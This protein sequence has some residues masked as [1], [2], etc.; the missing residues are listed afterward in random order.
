MRRDVNPE[1]DAVSRA[2]P[3][4]KAWL[5][6]RIGQVIQGRFAL[7]AETDLDDGD[8]LIRVEYAAVSRH[9]ALA[10]CGAAF[11]PSRLPCI[12][13]RDLVGE[14]IASSAPRFRCGDKVIATGY[15]LGLKHHGAFAEIALVPG[16]WLLPLPQTLTM[17]DSMILGSAGVAI[18]MAVSRLE[19]NGLRP[20]RGPVLVSG[21][22]GESG[23][24]A[25]ALL[26]ARGYEVVALS[27]RVELSE[28]LRGIGASKVLACD[29]LAPSAIRQKERALWA[30][31]IDNQGSE[32]L[33]WILASAKPGAGVVALGDA[34]GK[35]DCRLSVG[36]FWVRGV[37]LF[38][39]DATQ[40][41][42]ASKEKAWARLSDDLLTPA[43]AML[44]RVVRF[45]ELPLV[46]EQLLAGNTR[47]R[48]VVRIA[49]QGGEK[50][51]I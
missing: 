37:S 12:G 28:W 5:I 11:L 6:E 4:F 23:S 26:A 44:H 27:Q 47:G 41:G 30:G 32:T 51:G 20:E 40:A 9:D 48:T 43:L 22:D 25:V 10:S 17:L 45:E 24:L 35:D 16:G 38:G 14:V 50:E 19:D 1:Q 34:A 13:G 29:E 7:L 15:G 18:A 8:V 21:A 3:R 49:T 36:Q 33:A 46:F 31:A 42:F 2:A 39:I